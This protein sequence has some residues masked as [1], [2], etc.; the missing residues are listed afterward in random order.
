MKLLCVNASS[1]TLKSKTQNKLVECTG[2]NLKEEQIY[3]TSG[4]PFI[5]EHGFPSYYIKG[6]GIKLTCRFTKLIEEKTSVSFKVK[7]EDLILN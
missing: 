4:E 3:E 6:L 7:K 1:I 2:D 5:D